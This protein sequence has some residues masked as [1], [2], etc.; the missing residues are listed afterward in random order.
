MWSSVAKCKWEILAMV[1]FEGNI[2]KR[3]SGLKIV[4]GIMLL[5]SILSSFGCRN[6]LRLPLVD[7]SLA[8][9]DGNF[10]LY[11]SGTSTVINRV[12][13]Q[14]RIDGK[15]VVAEYFD[16]RSRKSMRRMHHHHKRFVLSLP[17][18]PHTIDIHSDQE[19][20]NLKESFTITDRHWATVGFWYFPEGNYTD[21]TTPKGFFFRIQDKRIIFQ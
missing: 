1:I 18:G 7:N 4:F 16:I 20:I 2:M 12:D 9:K 14:I 17:K 19:S 21:S 13:I 11:V 10:T 8:S 5:I 6:D 15:V 3:W